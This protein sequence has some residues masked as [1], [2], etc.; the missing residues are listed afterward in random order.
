MVTATPHVPAHAQASNLRVALWCAG[1]LAS[2]VLLFYSVRLAAFVHSMFAHGLS[3]IL[4]TRD[5]ANYWMAGHLAISGEQ[6]ELFTQSAYY[7]RLK[8][9]FGAD[10]PIHN[11]GYPPHVL[12]LLWPLG[13]LQYKPALVSFLSLTLV[14]LVTA[15]WSFRRTYAPHASC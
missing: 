2:L 6:Q 9:A 5:F 15:V 3:P 8:Q 10:Y 11:W 12:L 7:E 14:M 1:I 4:A 13:L